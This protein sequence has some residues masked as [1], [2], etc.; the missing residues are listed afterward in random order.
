MAR[1]E[2]DWRLRARVAIAVALQQLPIGASYQQ[3][4]DA[5]F[6]AYPFGQRRHHPYRIFCEEQRAAL[7]DFREQPPI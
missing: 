7:E 4:R 1:H 5:L 3:A 2:S 6:A